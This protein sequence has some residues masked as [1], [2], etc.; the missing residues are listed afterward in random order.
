MMRLSMGQRPLSFPLVVGALGLFSACGGAPDEVNAPPAIR[1]VDVF[2]TAAVEG[3]AS[4]RPAIAPTEWRFD[5]GQGPDLWKSGRGVAELTVREG[6]L[7]GTSTNDFPIVHIERTTELDNVDLL[8]SVEVRVRVSKGTNLSMTVIGTEE[9]DFDRLIERSAVIPWPLRTPIVAGDELQ[10]YTMTTATAAFQTSF[11]SS[12]IRH[13]LLRPTDASGADFE[14]ESVRL[15]FRSE[16]LAGIPSG[17]SWQGFGDI[18]RETIVTRSPE[19][20]RF[21]MILPQQPM[22][23]LAVGTVEDGP[24]RFSVAINQGAN[25][26]SVLERTI[27]TPDR[28]EAVYVDLGKF[29]GD[30]VTLSLGVDAEQEGALGFWGAPAVRSKAVPPPAANGFARPQ[31]VVYIFVD[32]LRS[33]HLDAYGYDRETAPTVSRLAAEGTLFRDNIAQGAWTKVSAPSMYTAFYPS[34]LGIVD[35]TDRVPSAA[36]TMAEA[37]REAGYATWATSSVPFTGRLANMHQ[38]LEVL[39]ERGSFDSPEGQSGSKTARE[40]VDRLLP[41]L[42]ASI[43]T[44][45]S[46]PS[47]IGTTV[48]SAVPTPSSSESWKSSASS[49]WMK[50]RWSYSSAIMARSF[51]ITMSTSTRWTST[52]R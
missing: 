37:Y 4:N 10:T 32:T 27:T 52:V 46:E 6:R 5:K 45:S 48:R 43:R 25:T 7:R 49:G 23:D 11:P 20:V 19:R 35:F 26:F 41:W 31:G 50:K 22:L 40:F 2:Q 47:S 33:D 21:T 9:I 16:H 51:W 44:R 12:D 34:T 38:G 36:V 3:A 1:L 13:I 24:I 29:A 8:H 42:A 17:V 28:W 18:F 15:I 14:I 39:H 30:T